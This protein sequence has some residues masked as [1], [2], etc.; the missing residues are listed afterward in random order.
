V[1]SIF[2]QFKISYLIASICRNLQF[3]IFIFYFLYS[4]I[5]VLYVCLFFFFFF[6]KDWNCNECVGIGV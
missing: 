1:V 4:C 6:A 3:F 5:W 2:N